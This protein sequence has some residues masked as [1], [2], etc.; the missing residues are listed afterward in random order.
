MLDT[1][2]SIFEKNKRKILQEFQTLGGLNSEYSLYF[3]TFATIPYL[4]WGK[5][6]YFNYGVIPYN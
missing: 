6:F 5:L 1:P 2:L 4:K 3:Y